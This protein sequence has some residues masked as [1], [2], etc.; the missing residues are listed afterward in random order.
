MGII[1]EGRLA[2]EIDPVVPV[3]YAYVGTGQV[4]DET[5]NYFVAYGALLKRRKVLA[6][7]RPWMN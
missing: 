2:R 6:I 3:F 4:A 7:D 1:P 5:R